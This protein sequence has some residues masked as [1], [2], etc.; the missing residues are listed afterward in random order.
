MPEFA[1]SSAR[2]WISICAVGGV[3]QRILYTSMKS[4]VI[5]A[6]LICG[7]AASSMCRGQAIYTRPNAPSVAIPVATPVVA[8][9]EVKA[10]HFEVPSVENEELLATFLG[11]K[12]FHCKVVS[13]EGFGA[14]SVL[15]TFQRRNASGVMQ[16]I[17]SVMRTVNFVE[18]KGSEPITLYLTPDKV[19]LRIAGASE[20]RDTTA[21]KLVCEGVNRE[22]WNANAG[23]NPVTKP[24]DIYIGYDSPDKKSDSRPISKVQFSVVIEK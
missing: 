21:F 19:G 23:N 24:V 5:G 22:T 4:V 15:V 8:G 12:A 17:D 18:A 13:K 16:V 14:I 9:T 6:A 2:G 3:R 20:T 7:F 10:G 1:F 11:I